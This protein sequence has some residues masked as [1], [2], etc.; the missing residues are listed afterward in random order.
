MN[1]QFATSIQDLQD[2]TYSD[3]ESVKQSAKAIAHKLNNELNNE[4]RKPKQDV[5]TTEYLTKIKNLEKMLDSKIEDDNQGIQGIITKYCKDMMKKDYVILLALI[6]LINSEEFWSN[7][8][9][10]L[11]FLDD[12][13]SIYVVVIKALLIVIAYHLVN[14]LF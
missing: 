2:N 7:V 12:G 3:S 5:E 13:N 9:K 14:N 6:I 8:N 4:K 10:Y 1:E 11:P